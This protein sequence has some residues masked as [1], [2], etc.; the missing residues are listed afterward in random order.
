MT[1]CAVRTPTAASLHVRRILTGCTLFA[2]LLSAAPP[3]SSSYPQ[4]SQLKMI[5]RSPSG[6]P[7]EDLREFIGN[8]KATSMLVDLLSN[9]QEKQWWPTIVTSL[10]YI[11]SF[12]RDLA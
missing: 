3:A 7:K 9:E 5:V 8:P 6:F 11:A 12:D 1:S 2:A 10:G 4:L